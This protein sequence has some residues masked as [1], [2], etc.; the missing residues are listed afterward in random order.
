MKRKLIELSE[1]ILGNLLTACAFGF[2]I[3]PQ[4]FVA[5][6]VTGLAIIL[7]EFI[8]INLSLI[9]YIING[10]L[11]VLGFLFVGKGFIMKTLLS[12]LLFPLFLQLASQVTLFAP[13]KSDP[14]LSVL[15]AGAALGLGSG[16]VLRGN[17]SSGGFDILGVIA[18]KYIN[19][20]ITLVMYLCDTAVILMQMH[21]VMKTIYGIVI[22]LFTNLMINRVLSY[23]A[24]QSSLIII[25]P[26]YQEISEELL[27]HQ[28]IGL[29]FLNAETG[30]Y[31]ESTK[32]IMAVTPY[33]KINSIKQAIHTIDPTAFVIIEDVRSVLGKGYTLAKN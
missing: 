32:V 5:G 28:D 33:N 20:P 8:P 6:G 3:L 29:T 17:G 18:H 13:L 21:S 7:H 9:I 23:G 26:H 22:I 30:Y 4:D 11:F 10:L 31:K 19:I 27:H 14:L 24:A 25:S 16:L 1:I 15:I 2:I 12:T